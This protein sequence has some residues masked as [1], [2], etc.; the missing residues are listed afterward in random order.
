MLNTNQID[1]IPK[2]ILM[3]VASFA[4]AY[5]SILDS[6]KPQYN[7]CPSNRTIST[8]AKVPWEFKWCILWARNRYKTKSITLIATTQAGRAIRSE[9]HTSELQSQSNLL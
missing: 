1:I 3:N 9:E 7:F 5:D 2:I 6:S 8:L 4:F